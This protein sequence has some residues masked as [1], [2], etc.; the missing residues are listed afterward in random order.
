MSLSA[1]RFR[2]LDLDW[3]WCTCVGFAVGS[4]LC[5]VFS[6]SALLIFVLRAAKGD[7][8]E[9]DFFW[10]PG[11]FFAFVFLE[12][13]GAE[14][15]PR[16]LLRR[17]LCTLLATSVGVDMWIG[18]HREDMFILPSRKALFTYKKSEYIVSKWHVKAAS[19]IVTR[20]SAYSGLIKTNIQIKKKTRIKTVIRSYLSHLTLF[21]N[22]MRRN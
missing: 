2:N 22:H 20:K 11:D 13:F 21:T 18:L 8:F 5:D 1:K 12:S 10:Y 14:A 17:F 19:E 7:L 15:F 9:R 6:I 3:V 4:I 16:P